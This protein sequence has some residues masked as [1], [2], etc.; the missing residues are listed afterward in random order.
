VYV[1]IVRI[2]CTVS[3]VWMIDGMCESVRVHCVVARGW[4]TAF[5]GDESR[6]DASAA[7]REEGSKLAGFARMI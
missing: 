5:D 2:A 3:N 6:Q 7:C 1:G 4:P